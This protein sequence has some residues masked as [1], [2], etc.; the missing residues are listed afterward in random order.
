MKN[1][2]SVILIVLFF[3]GIYYMSAGFY[4]YK[5]YA[6]IVD[7]TDAPAGGG[8]TIK[9]V[10]V[11]TL[12]EYIVAIESGPSTT[13]NLPEGTYNIFACV[14]PETAQLYDVMV[15][16]DLVIKLEYTQGLC[17]F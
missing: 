2:F 17:P 14:F 12:E 15:T 5:T 13:F 9:A 10:N 6:I 7:N 16:G 8:G 3:G 4:S 1:F 11:N